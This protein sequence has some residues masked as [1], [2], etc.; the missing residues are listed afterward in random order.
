MQASNNS[1]LLPI[2]SFLTD[3]NQIIA[4]PEIEIIEM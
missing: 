2:S 3:I 4:D 1:I